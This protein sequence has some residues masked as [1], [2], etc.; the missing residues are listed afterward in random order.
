MCFVCIRKIFDALH[1]VAI[2]LVILAGIPVFTRVCVHLWGRFQWEGR[3]RFREVGRN[4][5]R[6]CRDLVGYRGKD[7]DAGRKAVAQGEKN[8]PERVGKLLEI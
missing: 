3:N 7:W 8:R 2:F 6:E 1:L 4:R 5:F